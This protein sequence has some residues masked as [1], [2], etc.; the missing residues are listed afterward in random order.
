MDKCMDKFS[1]KSE[2][3]SGKILKNWLI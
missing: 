1:D 3:E 2:V